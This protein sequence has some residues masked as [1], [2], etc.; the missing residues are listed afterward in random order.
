MKLRKK[1]QIILI[2][3]MTRGVELV[4]YAWLYQRRL[5]DLDW[6][7]SVTW[8]LAALG[9]DLGYYCVHRLVH[10]VSIGWAAHQVH[11]S[12]EEYNLS[13]ALRQSVFQKFFA[14]GFYLP[15]ALIGV[16]LPAILV[17]MQFNLLY[18]FW[19]HTEVVSTLGPLELVLNTPSHHRVHHGANPWCLDKNYAGVLI[20]W[21][22][23]F[24]T[25]E[26]ERPKEKIIYGLVD[27]PQ[28]FNVPWLQVFYYRDT[29]VK[30]AKQLTWADTIKSLFYGP[31]WCPGSPRLGFPLPDSH[32]EPRKKY[33]PSLPAIVELYLFSHFLVTLYL[34]QVLLNNFNSHSCASVLLHILY[35]LVTLGN[36]GALYDGWRG[37]VLL[38]ALRCV[39]F[40]FWSVQSPL[41]GGGALETSVRYYSAFSAVVWAGLAL[42]RDSLVIPPSGGKKKKQ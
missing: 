19:I 13:T 27:Q 16:P 26:A 11:H 9:V 6:N 2:S 10:E 3:S 41:L 12:S 32:N 30:A 14:F 4:G 5:F 36:F 17:H 39:A 25:F 38:E 15:L 34:Q 21:D 7:S 29:F 8:W 40:L 23:M 22:R 28:T 31:G 24:G 1:C 20:I 37:A 35:M 33:N 18:Q 42:F